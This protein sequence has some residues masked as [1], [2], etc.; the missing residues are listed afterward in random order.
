MYVYIDSFAGPTKEEY[1]SWPEERQKKCAMMV[2][3][4]PVRVRCLDGV[5]WDALKGMIKRSEGSKLEPKYT[6]G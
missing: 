3:H 2:D 5:E 4:L 6:V 1:E